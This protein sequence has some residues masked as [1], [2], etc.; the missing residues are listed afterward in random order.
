MGPGFTVQGSK[1]T[2]KMVNGIKQLDEKHRCRR[3]FSIANPLS[4]LAAEVKKIWGSKRGEK[5]IG[6]RRMNKI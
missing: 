6:I 4:L 1:A 5:D 2:W 3:S